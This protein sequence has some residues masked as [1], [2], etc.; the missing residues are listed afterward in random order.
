MLSTG[1]IV[2]WL[3]MLK[4]WKLS[5]SLEDRVLVGDEDGI[6][7]RLEADEDELEEEEIEV[8]KFLVQEGLLWV[9]REVDGKI[10]F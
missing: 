7:E 4:V 8:R 1:G 6:R 3:R 5:L 2:F 9:G 10:Y